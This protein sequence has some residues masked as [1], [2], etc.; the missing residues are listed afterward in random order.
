MV[1]ETFAT[2]SAV[3]VWCSNYVKTK[4]HFIVPTIYIVLNQQKSI[5]NFICKILLKKLFKHLDMICN[6]V[7]SI[8]PDAKFHDA[9]S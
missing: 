9:G 1:T 5:E 8:F 2:R 6:P 7:H 3:L 4:E